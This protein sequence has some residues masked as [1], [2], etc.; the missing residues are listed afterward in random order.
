MKYNT[1]KE[2]VS[3]D[4]DL[5]THMPKA[6]QTMALIEQRAKTRFLEIKSS[7]ERGET[8]LEE[9]KRQRGLI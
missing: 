7:I 6:L 3:H 8:T 4:K 5:F 9:V 2:G 1:K